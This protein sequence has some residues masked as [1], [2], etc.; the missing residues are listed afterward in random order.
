LPRAVV[1]KKRQRAIK[2]PAFDKKS[3]VPHSAFLLPVLQ[4]LHQPSLWMYT[5][6]RCHLPSHRPK[7]TS[8]KIAAR[9]ISAWVIA[10][11]S[12]QIGLLT[13]AAAQDNTVLRVPDDVVV[14]GATGGRAFPAKA[15]RGTLRVLQAPEILIDGKP[16]RLSPGGRI[17]GPQNTLVLTGALQGNDYVVNFVRDSY[18]NVH[19]VWIL[20]PEEIKQKI[21]SA[22][23]ER[24]FLFSSESDQPK[25]DDGKTPFN[26]LPKYKQ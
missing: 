25:V 20:T 23:P 12:S 9:A 24:N 18:G 5:M 2:T 16:E 11:L 1:Y 22:T 26:Q 7:A 10:I 4:A 3:T 17:R 14:S 6:N 15:V 19:Q 8:K 21:K 13:P